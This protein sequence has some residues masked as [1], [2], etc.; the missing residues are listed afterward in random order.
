MRVALSNEKL[1]VHFCLF[2]ALRLTTRRRLRDQIRQLIH[3][4]IRKNGVS[5]L[6]A[7]WGLQN[8][9]LALFHFTFVFTLVTICIIIILINLSSNLSQITFFK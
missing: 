5:L 4:N 2:E 3:A 9:T 1:M 8:S 6:N 7:L